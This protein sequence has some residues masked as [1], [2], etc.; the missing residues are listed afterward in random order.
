MNRASREERQY[1]RRVAVASSRLDDDGPPASLAEAFDRLEA[2][3][4]RLHH[5]GRAGVD[6]PHGGDL[7]SHL[8]FLERLRTVD[9]PYCAR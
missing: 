3:E 9:P 8:A 4:R 7:D 2:M 1:F 5:L 6:G